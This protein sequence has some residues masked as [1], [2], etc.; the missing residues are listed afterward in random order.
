MKSRTYTCTR[1]SAGS[2]FRMD[3]PNRD[4]GRQ[5]KFRRTPSQSKIP[6]GAACWWIIIKKMYIQC[7]AHGAFLD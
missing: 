7:I 1:L 6:V 2:I 5:Y 4:G 3:Q